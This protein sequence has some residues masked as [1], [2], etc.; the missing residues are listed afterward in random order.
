MLKPKVVLATNPT[1]P[2]NT[3]IDYEKILRMEHA[4]IQAVTERPKLRS[5]DTTSYCP[6]RQILVQDVSSVRS[7][8][9]HG[10]VIKYNFC[11][12]PL[13]TT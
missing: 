11:I 2:V 6:T 1:F 9:S 12:T 3:D 10:H 13:T 4:E 8:H 7:S 5:L